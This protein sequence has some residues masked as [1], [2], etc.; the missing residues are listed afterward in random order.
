MSQNEIEEIE[1]SIEEAKQVVARGD[2]LNKLINTPEFQELVDKGYFN[3]EAIRLVNLYN[4]PSVPVDARALVANDLGGI[5][6]F[7]RYLRVIGMMAQTAQNEIDSHKANL[8]YIQEEM[9]QEH[10]DV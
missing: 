3:D 2:L 10:G 5:G 7:K 6:A 1:V 4:D 9:S 8:E